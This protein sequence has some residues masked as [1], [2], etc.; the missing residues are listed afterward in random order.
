MP[1]A[2]GEVKSPSLHKEN[3]MRRLSI[4]AG[5]LALLA[6]VAGGCSDAGPSDLN[7]L[8]FNLATRPAP[9]AARG[10][11]YG[12]IGTP[13]TFSDG[14]NTLIISKV[15]LVLRE[16][17]LHRAGSLA[18][19]ATGV[20]DVCEELEIGPLLPDVPLGTQG[21]ARN[22][23]VQL[24]PGSYDQV[25]FE[26]HK[27]SPSDDVAFVQ[28]HPEMSD[29]SVRV[30]GTYNGSAFTYIGHF[31][32]EMKFSLSPA[33]VANE[34][35]ASDLTL[36]VNLDQWF[37]NQGGSLLDPSTAN[38][39]GPNSGVV[40]QNIKTSLEAFEDNDHDGRDDHGI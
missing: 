19:C 4:R 33:L 27:A 30:S 2:C 8:S 34:T 18:D 15:E 38:S 12:I 36:F 22:F 16:I 29:A 28:A 23:S 11:S 13:E 3:G 35:A 25:E 20:D 37:R 1:V 26:I 39:G 21:A 32:V 31:D 24:T 9:A 10:T 5:S 7:Q 6:L 40:E 17:E 14:A